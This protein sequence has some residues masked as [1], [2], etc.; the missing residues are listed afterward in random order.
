M[1]NEDNWQANE[2]RIRGPKAALVRDSDLKVGKYYIYRGR[3]TITNA[4]YIAK[5][6]KITRWLV[7][8]EVTIDPQTDLGE[9]AKM[10]A[11]SKYCTAI[12]RTDIGRTECLYKS[13][14]LNALYN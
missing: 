12:Q 9:E 13:E 14:V 5:V 2:A 7:V 1:L 11:P 3:S 8:L 10:G 6:E 4:T